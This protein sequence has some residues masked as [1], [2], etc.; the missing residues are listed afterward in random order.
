MILAQAERQILEAVLRALRA[1]AGAGAQEGY[2]LEALLARATTTRDGRAD[3][4]AC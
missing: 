2:A 3:G 1:A 4:H